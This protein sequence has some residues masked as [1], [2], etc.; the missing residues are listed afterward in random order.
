M[1]SLLQLFSWHLVLCHPCSS[2]LALPC[3]CEQQPRYYRAPEVI[4]GLPYSPAVDL[5]SV[6]CVLYELYTGHIMFQGTTNNEM[7]WRFQEVKGR[8][9]NRMVRKHLVAYEHLEKEPHFDERLR[10][11]HVVWDDVSWPTVFNTT[12]AIL[13]FLLSF[14]LPFLPCTR[15]PNAIP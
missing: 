1:L 11:K 14:V 10:F 12:A 3:H 6:G 2:R 5:W 7:L 9:P 8:F 4:L 13:T 15:W